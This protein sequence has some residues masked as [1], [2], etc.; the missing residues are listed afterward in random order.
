MKSKRVGLLLMTFSV[1]VMMFVGCASPPETMVTEATS[2]PEATST[3]VPEETATPLSEAEAALLARA[4][5]V[6]EAQAAYYAELGT[7]V[8]GVAPKDTVIAAEPPTQAHDSELQIPFGALPPNGGTHHPSWQKCG[9]YDVPVK[10]QHAIHS[11]EHGA[12]WI[13]YQPNLDAGQLEL[14]QNATRGNDFVLLAPYPELGSPVV[15]TAWGVQL[16]LDSAEDSRVQE[17]IGAYANGPQSPE[18]GADCRSG[19]TDTIDTTNS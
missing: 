16:E 9:V 18:P 7:R 17:F 4:T 10:P 12:V 15:M 8:A 1:I 5:E 2:E 11:M 14:L 3:P 6:A 19:V 13:A